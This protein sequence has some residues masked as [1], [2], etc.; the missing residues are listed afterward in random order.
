MI[1]SDPA[2]TEPA[3]EQTRSKQ[4]RKSRCRRGCGCLWRG[5]K[6]IVLWAIMASVA[7]VLC[8]NW[9][10]Q[11]Q[12]QQVL[13]ELRQRGLATS[14][15][16]II[17][18][19][20]AIDPKRD[21]TRYYRA[22]MALA[23]PDWDEKEDLPVIGTGIPPARR[24]PIDDALAQRLMDFARQHHNFYEVCA[25]AL[26]YDFAG[27][28]PLTIETNVARLS[29]TRGVARYLQL[30]S[31]ERCAQGDAD[32]AIGAATDTLT[33][34]H[35]LRRFPSVL[36]DLT[37]VHMVVYAAYEAEA[38]LSRTV[39][40][41][42]ALD[43]YEQALRRECESL[44]KT[45]GMET[46]IA[47]FADALKHPK[48]ASARDIVRVEELMRTD[49]YGILP[50]IIRYTDIDEDGSLSIPDFLK[51]SKPWHSRLGCDI[52]RIWSTICPGA[53]QIVTANRIRSAL[54]TYDAYV[55]DPAAVF[56]AVDLS[57]HEQPLRSAVYAAGSMR[58]YKTVVTTAIHVE[59]YRIEHGDWPESLG[60]LP[61][62][63]PTDPYGEE[64][65][66]YKSMHDGVIVYSV[67][68]NREDD[69]GEQ[70]GVFVQ[71]GD[72]AF[73][74]FDPQVRGEKA[75]PTTDSEDERR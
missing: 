5:I 42:S 45:T 24:H 67:G 31:M 53:Q 44:E 63:R 66:R 4:P 43:D 68:P 46:E 2:H 37:R 11:R 57:D 23:T 22:A 64:P 71:D 60:D 20:P 32:G 9:Y 56:A 40:S 8:A 30:R 6:G 65:L 72:V 54:K 15:D 49:Q 36:T 26:D 35:E 25:T 3:T 52:A 39:P 12:A 19:R 14:Y 29:G 73:R 7:Y 13:D 70:D 58:T 28:G 18:R 61:D 48:L 62:G 21:G 41:A 74:L 10:G 55:A 50:V 33:W 34:S 59:R 1:M 47:L 51:T 17:A 38:V 69:G 75:A 16:E 27:D